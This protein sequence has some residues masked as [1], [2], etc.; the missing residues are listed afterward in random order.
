MAKTLSGI[1]NQAAADY[2]LVKELLK[3]GA[4]PNL[5]EAPKPPP[6]AAPVKKKF[7]P[8]EVVMATKRPVRAP[9]A[10]R[11]KKRTQAGGRKQPAP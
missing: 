10:A 9:R 5:R 7:D 8:K 6:P 1:F 4:D 11:W 2:D 3:N